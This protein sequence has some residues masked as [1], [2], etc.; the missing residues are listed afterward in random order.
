MVVESPPSVVIPPVVVVELSP[1][2]PVVAVCSLAEERTGGEE[3]IEE[4]RVG[5]KKEGSRREQKGY[6]K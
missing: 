4:E 5:K 6:Q 3:G 2:D 1:S